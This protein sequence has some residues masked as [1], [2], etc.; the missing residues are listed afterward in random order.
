MC[1]KSAIEYTFRLYQLVTCRFEVDLGLS[2]AHLKSM[3][4]SFENSVHC[5][6]V[7]FDTYANLASLKIKV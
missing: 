2:D 6:R 1:L 4:T 3:R 7:I 5:W